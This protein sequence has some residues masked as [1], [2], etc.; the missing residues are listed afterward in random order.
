MR[1][2]ILVVEDDANLVELACYNLE[3]EGFEVA[4][5]GDGEEA[6]MLA[7]E[8]KPD[9]V[10]LDWMIANLPMDKVILRKWLKA[11]YVY[12]SKLFPSLSGTP[13][14]GIIS[15]VLANMTNAVGLVPA[16]VGGG[17]GYREEVREHPRLNLLVL[18]LT[19]LSGLAGAALLLAPQLYWFFLI[20]RGACRLFR[21]RG[22]PPPSPCQTKD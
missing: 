7:E 22:T 9:L 17:L 5:T 8:E 13:Q 12:Q 14:G 3:K 20:C 18:V 11:G 6:L 16:G 15:P 10:I 2:N 1:P 21:P 19:G 4:K